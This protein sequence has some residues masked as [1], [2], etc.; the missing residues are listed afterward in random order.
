MFFCFI[1]EYSISGH[2]EC[3]NFFMLVVLSIADLIQYLCFEISKETRKN[4]LLEYLVR[5]IGFAILKV[6]TI[7]KASRLEGERI[8]NRFGKTVAKR[9]TSLA[10][11]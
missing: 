8:A 9:D 2:W 4:H 11:H 5:S 3:A 7:L 1:L 10:C 6:R